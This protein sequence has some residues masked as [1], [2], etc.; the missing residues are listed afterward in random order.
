MPSRRSFAAMLAVATAAATTVQ[1][2]SSPQ[3][4]R[5]TFEQRFSGSLGAW[6]MKPTGELR[7]NIGNG[8]GFGG[9]SLFRLDRTGIVALRADIGLGGYGQESKHVPLS[10]T[11]G[12]RIQVDVVTRNYVAVGNF[13]PQLTLPNGVVRPY[14]NAGVG[15]Q[16]FFTESNVEGDDDSHSF[17]STTNQSDWTPTF[18]AGGGVYVPLPYEKCPV[19]LDFGFTWYT[20][21]RATYLKPGSIEDLPNS[22]IRI[23]PLESAT[24]FVLFRVGVKIGR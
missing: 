14:V 13:G 19:L 18:A 9:A 7:D 22:E 10:P 11:V 8:I 6:F 16:A 15:F 1:A 2:Q 3:G 23:T 17:A 24:P 4:G 21:G 20:G 5:S 12:G